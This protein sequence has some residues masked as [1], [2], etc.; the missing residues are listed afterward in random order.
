MV[1][2]QPA[3]CGVCS[4]VRQSLVWIAC[5][6]CWS[7]NPSPPAPLALQRVAVA[8]ASPPRPTTRVQLDLDGE[9]ELA[10]AGF[11]NIHGGSTTFSGGQAVIRTGSYEEWAQKH[12]FVGAA[13][14]GPWAVETRVALDRT[15]GRSGTGLWIHDGHYYIGIHIT[16]RELVYTTSKQR[17][18]IGPTD[19]MRV[20]R[21]ELDDGVAT[22]RVDGRVVLRTQAQVQGASVVLM[23]GDLGNNCPGS[24]SSWDYLAYE[25]TIP[26]TIAWPPASEWHPGTTAKQLRRALASALPETARMIPVLRDADVPCVALLAIDSAVRDL[27]PLTYDQQAA[28]SA[29]VAE[30]LRQLQPLSDPEAFERARAELSRWMKDRGP[31]CE[32]TRGTCPTPSPIVPIPPA[33]VALRDALYAAEHWS[34]HPAEAESSTRLVAQAYADAVKGKVPGASSALERLRNELTALATHPAR[35]GL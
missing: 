6:A 16:D 5:A 28:L 20:Y 33:A 10:A 31:P 34:Q 14:N 17:V 8:P 12:G 32:P 26:P 30:Q 24:M 2:Q 27:L 9:A 29:L 22:V 1:Q 15:C 21:I 11:E 23:F 19:H 13:A 4:V 3:R 18:E 25:T 35:C 7:G